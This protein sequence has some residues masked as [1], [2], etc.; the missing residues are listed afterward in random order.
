MHN[1]PKVLESAI[2]RKRSYHHVQIGPS[3]LAKRSQGVIHSLQ[4]R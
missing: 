1:V 4:D 3:D 2:P